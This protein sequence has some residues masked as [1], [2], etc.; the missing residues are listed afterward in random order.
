MPIDASHFT[1][2]SLVS[3]QAGYPFRGR[4]PCVQSGAVQVV[5]M[6]D[7]R[8]AASV[9][10]PQVMRTE[11]PSARSA[12]WLAAGDL[13]F[14]GRG[15]QFYAGCVDEPPGRAVC[16]PHIFHLRV[17]PE[18]KVLPRFLAWLINQPPCQKQLHLAAEG[19]NQLSIRRGGLEQLKLRI[20][21]FADQHRI[22]ALADLAQREQECLLQLIQNRGAQLE[23][24]A[25]EL[26]AD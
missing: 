21:S 6:K 9:D 11:L 4:I 13:L 10:W 1:L 25:E 24:L 26:S 20:P 18:A 3:I 12:D 14:V 17:Q 8:P 16:S 22:V 7:I 2:K 19:S 15:A 5:Q 23:A